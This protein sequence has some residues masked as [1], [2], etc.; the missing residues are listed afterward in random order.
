VVAEDALIK[1]AKQVI[2]LWIDNPGRPFMRLKQTLR[3]DTVD[4][5]KIKLAAEN[6]QEGLKNLFNKDVRQT[7][8]FVQAGMK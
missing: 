6:W 5:I 8:E 1:R 2:S 3:A 7:L 4:R